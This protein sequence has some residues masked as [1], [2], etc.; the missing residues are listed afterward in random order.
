MREFLQIKEKFWNLTGLRINSYSHPGLKNRDKSGNKTL[1]VTSEQNQKYIMTFR[2]NLAYAELEAEVL[3]RLSKRNDALPKLI[4][5]SGNWLVQEYISGQRLSVALA[6]KYSKKKHETICN[7][8]SSLISIQEDAQEIGLEKLVKPICTNQVWRETKITA[9]KGIAK[10]SGLST[11]ELDR[12]EIL[13]VLKIKPLTFIKWDSRL[14]NGILKDNKST[15]WF[16]W[17]HCGRRAGID[18]LVWFLSDEWLNLKKD[19]EQIII[20]KFID[21]FNRREIS[22]PPEAY[23]RV[24]GTIHMCGRLFKILE[25]WQGRSSWIDREKCLNHDLMGVT[26]QETK[27]L[28]LKAARWANEDNLTSPLVPWLNN[29]STWIDGQKK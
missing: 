11:P 7:A 4:N 2:Y 29:L 27:R 6:T 1:L 19:D 9:L 3:K 23:L 15:C 5:R 21:C 28:A 25:L 12:E 10:V 8:I 13:K 24:F 14:G 22:V 18:D 26:A 16:D 17:E 20:N